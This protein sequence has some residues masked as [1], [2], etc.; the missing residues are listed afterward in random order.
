MVMTYHLSCKWVLH[1]QVSRKKGSNPVQGNDLNTIEKRKARVT[2]TS[3]RKR[4]LIKSGPQALFTL[5]FRR[6][7][8]TSW[9][10]MFYMG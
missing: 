1:F 8:L 7:S 5:R 6:T 2:A 3:L 10:D 4:G 9:L